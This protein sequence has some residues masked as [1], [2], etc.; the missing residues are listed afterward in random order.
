MPAGDGAP[1]KSRA[2]APSSPAP[3]A[4]DDA[5]RTVAIAS[6]LRYCGLDGMLEG[7]PRLRAL[8]DSKDPGD[9]VA[10][11]RVLGMVGHA[12]LQRA[13]ARLLCDAEPAVRREA[14]RA[15]V[16]VADPRL[17][18]LLAAALAE[19]ALAPAAARAIAALGDDAIPELEERFDDDA[20]PRA[21]RLVIPRVLAQ[22]GSLAALDALLARID[23]PDETLRQK[24]LASAS[25]LRRSLYAPPAPQKTIRACI[26]HEIL[27]HVR[28]REAYIAVRPRVAGPLLDQHMLRRLRKGLIRVLRL[29]E[30]AY[31]REVI[32]LVR[33]HVFGPDPALRANAFEVLESLLDRP[34]RERL[35][36]LVERLL[37]LYGGFP[38]MPAPPEADVVAWIRGELSRGDPYSAALAL[39]AV[40]QHAIHGAAED[41]LA[42]THHPDPLVREAAAIAV[43]VTSP[44]GAAE[45]LAALTSDE[46]P[47]VARF[48]R[49]W[50]ASSGARIALEDAM[51]TTVEKILFLQQVP[52]F[53][54]VAGDDLVGL[55]RGALVVSLQKGDVIFR[56]GEPGGAL[57]LI[58]SGEVSITLD[59]REIARLG[60]NDVFGEMSLFD[61]EPRGS[62][63]TA[64]EDVELLRVAAEDFHEAMRETVEIAEAVIRVLNRRLRDADRRLADARAR[65]SCFPGP[66]RAKPTAPSDPGDEAPALGD[67]DLD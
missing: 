28:T 36:S 1:A 14:V 45:R 34:L 30:L 31:P 35:A 8:L 2:L 50:T 26:D 64:A 53:S 29:C 56:Q 9:R 54:R 33:A 12:S 18:P 20:T 47:A 13:L 21:A 43:A 51:Y 49:D 55:A 41:A 66:P 10:A 5:L 52:L 16:R 38:P 39:Y 63:A 46:D 37:E 24:V 4:P 61:D 32:A 7:A 6:L 11:A 57:Y 27:E 67:G 23:H 59:G 48:A 42:A 58:I 25:R 19:R 22:I 40:A 3:P 15:A 17:L 65:L 62:T 60:P 44:P